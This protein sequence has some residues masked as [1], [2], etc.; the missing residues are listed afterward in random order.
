MIRPAT[1][2]INRL[3][4]WPWRGQSAAMDIAANAGSPPASASSGRERPLA[5][6]RW[7]LAVAALVIAI[8]VIGGITRLTESG[9]SITEWKPVSGALPPLTEAQWQA[10]FDAYRQTPQYI[11]VNGPAGMT[12]ATYKFIFFWEWVHRLLARSIGLA[13]AAP[14][15]WFWVRGAIPRGYHVRLIALL[16]L[17]ALQGAVGW[18]MVKSGIVNDVKVSHLRLATHLLVALFTLGGLV[19]TALDL[20]AH[21]RGGR[22]HRL[23]G[24]GAL[25]LAALA[26][27]LGM[28]ALV[29]GLRAGHVAADWP[30]MTGSFFPEGVDWSAGALHAAL[31]DPFLTHFLHRWW[32]WVVV[33]ILVVM[34]RKLRRT[35][36][37]RV[38]VA[39]HSAFGVQVLLGI[40][41]V[42]SGI[43]LWLAVLHQL[44]GALLLCATVWG[45]HALGRRG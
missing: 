26:L 23:T 24:F 45:A 13:F 32:A 36:Q 10:E 6:A 35:G 7:L 2:P 11:L 4:L 41:T 30:L 44:I 31:S 12:L 42:M 37:R 8:V 3:A 34:G 5:L 33:A 28:G 17:G 40:A 15:A 19:W 43:A 29:A 21:A 39:V 38:S 22:P 20:I 18:W 27:Q 14:L 9:V 25:A 1:C 16:A